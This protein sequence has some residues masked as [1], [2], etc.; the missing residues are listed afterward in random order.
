M[1]DYFGKLST[2]DRRTQNVILI[3]RTLAIVKMTAC[4]SEFGKVV[5]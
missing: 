5:W 4:V 1:R 2:Q 3:S